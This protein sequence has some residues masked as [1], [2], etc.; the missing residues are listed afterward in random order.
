M[1][2]SKEKFWYVYDRVLLEAAWIDIPIAELKRRIEQGSL[3]DPKL[4]KQARKNAKG[5]ELVRWLGAAYMGL[6][7]SR[8][9][10]REVEAELNRDLLEGLTGLVEAGHGEK[11]LWQFYSSQRFY[12]RWFSHLPGEIDMDYWLLSHVTYTGVRF[13]EETF[14]GILQGP[15]RDRNLQRRNIV[16]PSVMEIP[17]LEEVGYNPDLEEAV[18]SIEE[19]Y[20]RERITR[21][22]YAD[23]AWDLVQALQRSIRF[24]REHDLSTYITGD[25]ELTIAPDLDFMLRRDQHR[26]P[27]TRGPKAAAETARP[28]EPVVADTG[29]DY[30]EP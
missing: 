6:Y 22:E 26:K 1:A 17:P 14:H 10:A 12:E 13:Q 3:L 18:L 7:K 23:P 20:L 29:D 8:R 11:S 28:A 25:K 15:C 19:S 4:T 9:E 27:P 21:Q 16:N 30:E 24:G 2:L 5:I